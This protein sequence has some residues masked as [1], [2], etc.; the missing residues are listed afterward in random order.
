M[1]NSD[2]ADL[3]LKVDDRQI[4]VP[5]AFLRVRSKEFNKQIA[6]LETDELTIKGSTYNAVY[7]TIHWLFNLTLPDEGSDDLLDIWAFADTYIVNE[8]KEECEER[9]IRSIE[10][11]T[12][13]DLIPK[14]DNVKCSRVK[15]ECV[16]FIVAHPCI[17]NKRKEM[18]GLSKDLI[19]DILELVKLD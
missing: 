3:T 19:L 13:L 11:G 8:L 1:I 2:Y 18:D 15:D 17:L 16:K 5:K 14:A 7:A 4:R 6:M 12:V 9:M 10:D